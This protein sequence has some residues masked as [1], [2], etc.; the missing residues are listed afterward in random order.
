MKLGPTINDHHG[1]VT[2]V[3][4]QN[5]WWD[6]DGF[7]LGLHTLLGPLRVPYAIEAFDKAGLSRGSSVLDVGS[8]GGFMTVALSETG[9]RVIGVD[10]SLQ[11]SQE[12]STRVTAQLVVGDGETLPFPSE[13]IDAAV[14]S[15]V[16]EHVDDAGAV[17]ADISR[18]L[19]PGGVLV[20]S[21]PNRTWLSRLVLIDLAQRF[22]FTRLL[23]ADLHEWDRFIRPEEFRE[24][25]HAHELDVTDLQGISLRARHVPSS[26]AALLGLKTGRITYAEAGERIQL[27][28][29]RSKAVAYIGTARKRG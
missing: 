23:P 25:A 6:Q 14:C 4:D 1:A 2:S 8:G 9:H 15:E 26:A 16:L 20:F 3:F 29:S 11:A 13:T 28:P 27:G 19:R 17:I 22:R 21:T 7:L 12:A 5:Q 24:L 10:P 18:V